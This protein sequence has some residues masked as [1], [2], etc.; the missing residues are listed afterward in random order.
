[1]KN[2]SVPRCD[3]RDP[4]GKRYWPLFAGRDPART[5]MQWSAGQNAGFSAGRPW[6]P[7][8]V[9]FQHVNVETES[10]DPYSLLN[11]YRRLIAIR[12]EKNA[13][14]SGE[15]KPVLKGHYGVLGYYRV[16]GDETIF[17]AL[18][19]TQKTKRVHIHDRGQW[20]VLI[21]THRF[22]N[23]YFTSLE[24]NLSPYEAMVVEKVGTLD[25]K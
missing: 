6:L 19:F 2:C 22:S 11:F 13:L 18:N 3:M 17:V 8:G 21:S 16:Q 15:W 12:K 9:D 5:P 23:T 24:F 20:K 7:V 4:L 25:A 14:N 10:A 1:M